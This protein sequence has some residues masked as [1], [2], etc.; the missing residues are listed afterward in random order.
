M[1]F[2]NFR[3]T[4]ILFGHSYIFLFSFLKNEKLKKSLVKP[5]KKPPIVFL[6]ILI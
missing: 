4:I 1:L 5:E 6:L 3:I 2:L